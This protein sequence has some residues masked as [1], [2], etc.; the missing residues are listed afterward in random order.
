MVIAEIASLNAQIA[1][2]DHVG[3]RNRLFKQRDR[4]FD[5]IDAHPERLALLRALLEQPQPSVRMAA[6]WRCAQRRVLLEEAKRAATELAERPKE[7]GQEAR[8]WLD[9]G[10]GIPPWR[11]PACRAK[12]EN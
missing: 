11:Q 10:A 2:T 4:L 7:I 9:R 6:A 5:A 3:R 8:A 12:F 1:A